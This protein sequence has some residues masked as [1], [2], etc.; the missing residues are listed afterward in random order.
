MN[1]S[2]SNTWDRAPRCILSCW[3]CSVSLWV[4]LVWKPLKRSLNDTN[5]NGRGNRAGQPQYFHDRGKQEVQRG[6]GGGLQPTVCCTL[7]FARSVVQPKRANI[8]ALSS[9]RSLVVWK[10]TCQQFVEVD[11][12]VRLMEKVHYGDY[13]LNNR[14]LAGKHGCTDPLW[15]CRKLHPFCAVQVF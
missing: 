4:A 9:W 5:G 8:L 11:E 13:I 14:W 1:W 6:V 15:A 3:L 7:S 10:R 12:S 2:S